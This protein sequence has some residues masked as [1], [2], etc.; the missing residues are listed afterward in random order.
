MCASASRESFDNESDFMEVS[1]VSVPRT[2]NPSE[3][4]IASSCPCR[5]LK[6]SQSVKS[7][8]NDLLEKKNTLYK[9]G[10]QALQQYVYHCVCFVRLN[11]LSL[12]FIL[13]NFFVYGG[14][15]QLYFNCKYLNI[16]IVQSDDR[17]CEEFL[18][19]MKN[20]QYFLGSPKKYWSFFT[21]KTSRKLN[22]HS[23]IRTY[24]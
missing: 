12:F 8:C 23:R 5:I 20:D 15:V 24:C 9:Q 3:A 6:I 10:R 4:G 16:S 22:F 14:T 1:K 2:I 19:K 13:L 21:E 11:T 17:G 18:F 7:A